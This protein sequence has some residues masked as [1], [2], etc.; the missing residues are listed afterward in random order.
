MSLC[1]GYLLCT[2]AL[3][4]LGNSSEA[5]HGTF[6]LKFRNKDHE[7]VSPSHAGSIALQ[8]SQVDLLLFDT[9]RCTETEYIAWKPKFVRFQF[10]LVINA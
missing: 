7:L 1:A 5:G 4:S 8:L 9:Q 6:P 3:L 2:E 10:V